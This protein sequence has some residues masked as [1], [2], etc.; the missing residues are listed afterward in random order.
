MNFSKKTILITI[1][2]LLAVCASIYLLLGY[3]ASYF[4]TPGKIQQIVNEQTG[5]VLVLENSKIRTLPDLSLQISADKFILSLPNSTD[6]V[7]NA[8][9]LRLR[10]RIL[11]VL[12]KNISISSFSVSSSLLGNMIFNFLFRVF[13]QC[14]TNCPRPAI[15][16]E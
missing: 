3:V 13:S 9:N 8:D 14:S 16:S 12:F 11:P 1:S 10:V 5:L 15:W 2:A 4:F 7:I 6:S